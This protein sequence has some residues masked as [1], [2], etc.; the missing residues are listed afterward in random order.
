MT[1]VLLNFLIALINQK[2]E[3]AIVNLEATQTK[4]KAELNKEYFIDQQDTRYKTAKD[5]VKRGRIYIL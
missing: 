2:Y 3:E 1:I 4:H 5:A